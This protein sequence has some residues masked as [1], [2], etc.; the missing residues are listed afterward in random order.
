MWSVLRVEYEHLSNTQGYRRVDYV[1]LHFETSI[2]SKSAGDEKARSKFQVFFEL[3][4]F[5][6]VVFAVALYA[7]IS[8]DPSKN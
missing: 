3:F 4:L 6:V 8:D 2:H 7:F 5:A 1:P